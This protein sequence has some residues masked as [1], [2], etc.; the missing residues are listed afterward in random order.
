MQRRSCWRRPPQVRSSQ[1][2]RGGS[3]QRC[4]GRV[5]WVR[6][7][8]AAAGGPFRR[9]SRQ[10]RR[11]AAGIPARCQGLPRAGAAPLRD[12]TRLAPHDSSPAR[13]P[14]QRRGTPGGVAARRRHHGYPCQ[15]RPSEIPRPL[16]AAPRQAVLLVCCLAHRAVLGLHAPAPAAGGALSSAQG[17]GNLRL[18]GGSEASPSLKD[19]AKR[20]AELAKKA[21]KVEEVGLSRVAV[22][23]LLAVRRGA[24]W[25]RMCPSI[26]AR[27]SSRA[28]C[29]RSRAHAH[30]RMRRRARAHTRPRAQ[31]KSV[32]ESSSWTVFRVWFGIT[33]KLRITGASTQVCVFVCVCVCVDC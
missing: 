6:G 7:A 2:W 10:Q 15:Q 29:V 12:S 14:P 13:P 16:L 3:S 30:T 24:A 25:S 11:A 4:S 1:K 21:E 22:R 27:D 17:L 19:V 33:N 32:A 18:T 26:L 23:A 5:Q 28:V 8:R 9:V 31:A 20:R